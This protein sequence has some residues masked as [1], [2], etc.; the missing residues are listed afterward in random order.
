VDNEL[1]AIQVLLRHGVSDSP[2]LLRWN[3]PE[4][5]SGACNSV[6]CISKSEAANFFPRQYPALSNRISG[7]L[8][9]EKIA[10]YCIYRPSNRLDNRSLHRACQSP[11]P[12]VV[13]FSSGECG[14]CGLNVPHFQYPRACNFRLLALYRSQNKPWPG[15]LVG[16]NR[17]EHLRESR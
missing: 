6:N 9:G 1:L 17:K 16:R 4:T 7:I 15:R 8:R 3:A 2:S 12:D 5:V 11:N 13:A 14:N 10:P